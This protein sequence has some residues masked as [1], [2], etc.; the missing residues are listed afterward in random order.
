MVRSQSVLVLVSEFEISFRFVSA[1]RVFFRPMP[2]RKLGADDDMDMIDETTAE[3]LARGAK[4]V[5]T[6]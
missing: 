2:T 4:T 3:G 6:I 1:P 5:S